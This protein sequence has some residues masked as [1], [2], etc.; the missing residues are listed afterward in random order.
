MRG[1]IGFMGMAM[2]LLSDLNDSRESF[3]QRVRDDWKKTYKMPRKMK[4]RVRKSLELD[5]Q[6]ANYD[7]FNIYKRRR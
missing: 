6:I 2:G 7:P 1:S 3:K 5:W 4:K